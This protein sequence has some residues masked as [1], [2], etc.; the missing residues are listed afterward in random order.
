MRFRIPEAKP[1]NEC[2]SDPGQLQALDALGY[3]GYR[4]TKCDTAEVL[5]FCID[6]RS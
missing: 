4:G 2:N 5:W 6:V 3:L 1:F